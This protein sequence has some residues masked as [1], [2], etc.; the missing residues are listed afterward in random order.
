MFSL[1]TPHRGDFNEYTQYIIFHIKK[2]LT[3]NYP[4]SAAMQ[5]SRGLKNE[6]EIAY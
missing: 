1:D 2:K 6:F 5:F 4:K 3:R